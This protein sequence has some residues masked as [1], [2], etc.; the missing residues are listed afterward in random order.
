MIGIRARNVG[1]A[2]AEGM[3]ELS[4]PTASRAPAASWLVTTA[5]DTVVL[6]GR[7]RRQLSYANRGR[8]VVLGIVEVA[9]W[10]EHPPHAPAVFDAR[11][12]FGAGP[13][14]HVHGAN[15][16]IWAS[17]YLAAA[18]SGCWRT[19][20][21]HALLAA[22]TE[23]GRPVVHASAISVRISGRRRRGPRRVQPPAGRPP[24][25]RT[26]GPSAVRPGRVA[27]TRRLALGQPAA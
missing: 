24:R 5:A 12:E 6:P 23:A 25:C 14:P 1:A 20:E 11:N 3:A 4:R 2:R 9:D 19:A 10:G 22:A 26:R 18:G 15:L 8:D 17:A 21:D 13:H 7:P 27:A 16:G